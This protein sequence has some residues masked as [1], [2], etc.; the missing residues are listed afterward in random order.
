MV[1][2]GEWSHKAV[3]QVISTYSESRPFP[4]AVPTLFSGLLGRCRQSLAGMRISEGENCYD[5]ALLNEYFE[6]NSY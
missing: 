5:L 2:A 6:K 3:I 1:S 4:H